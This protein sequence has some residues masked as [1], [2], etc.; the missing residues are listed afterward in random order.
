MAVSVDFCDSEQVD[1]VGMW[2]VCG[3]LVGSVCGCMWLVG[4]WYVVGMC[5]VCGCRY[6]VGMWLVL[7][8]R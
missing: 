1:L 6:M 8:V 7:Y 5:L 3:W 2:Y 4:G